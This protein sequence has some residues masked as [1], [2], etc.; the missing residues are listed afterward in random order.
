[1]RE[2]LNAARIRAR[3][4]ATRMPTDPLA[5]D[6]TH[7]GQR[8]PQTVVDRLRPG[9][10]AAGVLVPLIERGDDLR[11]LLTERAPDLKH[12]AGQVSFPGGGMEA[13]DADIL[14]TALREAQEEVGIRP[15]QVEIAGYLAPTAT[16]TGF[17]V[18]GVIGFV[19]PA[20]EPVPDPCEVDSVFEVPVGFL[21]DEGNARYSERLYEGRSLAVASFDYDGHRIWGATAGLILAFRDLIL[22]L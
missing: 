22:N 11:M 20:F 19:D 6:F 14:E 12:H 4:A 17:A 9:M 16:I 7:L 1:M 3:L 2:P 13:G 18:T 8:L 15:S 5:V 21:M 10:R